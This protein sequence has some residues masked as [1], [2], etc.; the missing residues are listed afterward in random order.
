[1][2]TQVINRNRESKK[3]ARTDVEKIYDNSCEMSQGHL[4]VVS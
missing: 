4:N 3:R 2:Y 1:M